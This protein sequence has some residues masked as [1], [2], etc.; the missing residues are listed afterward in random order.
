M[1]CGRTFNSIHKTSSEHP[2]NTAGK[3]SMIV[4]ITLRKRSG[5]RTLFSS[6]H[7]TWTSEEPDLNGETSW[8]CS[9][10]SF[11]RTSSSQLK[12]EILRRTK[13]KTFLKNW[14]LK[15]RIDQF[16]LWWS[17][18]VQ[19]PEDLQHLDQTKP[20]FLQML[21]VEV[22]PPQIHEYQSSAFKKLLKVLVS[23]CGSV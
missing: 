4:N 15:R 18:D 9:L 23:L 7:R 2:Q 6:H 14:T 21:M 12:H 1:F 22:G 19:T 3:H 11:L 17:P 20:C 13:T 8:E 5:L 16:F 10:R